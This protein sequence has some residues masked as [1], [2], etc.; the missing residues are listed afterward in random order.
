MTAASSGLGCAWRSCGAD[1]KSLSTLAAGGDSRREYDG[2]LGE[3]HRL[4]R[5]RW[6]LLETADAVGEALMLAVH[7]P[8]F[9]QHE[10]D[11]TVEA[12]DHRGQHVHV[13]AHRAHFVEHALLLAG[14]EFEGD[15]FVGHG[16]DV[17]GL[18][19]R[20][21]RRYPLRFA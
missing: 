7:G 14:E 8:Q 20:D 6:L 10:P 9:R 18:R 17:I 16:D 12:H 11:G 13:V 3:V 2:R 4:L 21:K 19:A 5:L 15:R 1:F